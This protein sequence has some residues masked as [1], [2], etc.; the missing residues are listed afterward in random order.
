MHSDVRKYQYSNLV[1]HLYKPMQ[2]V[3]R[4]T[5]Y[6]KMHTCVCRRNIADN[7]EAKNLTQEK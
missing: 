5:Y 2:D 1:K 4:F 7:N 6:M 3:S